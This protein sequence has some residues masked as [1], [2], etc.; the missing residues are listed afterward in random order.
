MSHPSFHLSKWYLDVVD[1]DGRSFIGYAGEVSWKGFRAPYTSILLHN[2]AE[3]ERNEFR[4][5][6]IAAP[7]PDAEN[8]TLSWKDVRFGL[9]GVWTGALKPVSV[10][11]F[12]NDE[13]F[14]DWRCYLPHA[15]VALV[16]E[17]TNPLNGRGY[18]EQIEITCPPWH[19][20]MGQ[21]RWGRFLS[22]EYCIIW[23]EWRTDSPQQWVFLNGVPVYRAQIGDDEVVLPEQ[24]LR[25]TLD[26][27]GNLESE[28]KI[29]QVAGRLLSFLPGF[30]QSAPA[31]FL[32]ADEYKWRSRARLYEQDILKNEGWAIHELVDF[33]R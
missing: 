10:R 11:L 4:L 16:L 26:R 13:G 6:H 12:E 30:K 25:F 8:N 33:S 18:A 22:E 7:E 9:S 14:V 17:N 32:Y 27:S 29:Q 19:I 5:H 20:P 23:I 28:K 31:R 15:R 21:L 24:G 1:D 2:G 3:T